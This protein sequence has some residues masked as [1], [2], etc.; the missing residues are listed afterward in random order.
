MK[1]SQI[2]FKSMSTFDN[3]KNKCKSFSEKFSSCEMFSMMEFIGCIFFSRYVCKT[4]GHYLILEFSPASR[5][6]FLNIHS[7]LCLLK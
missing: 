4:L 7:Q 6:S 2:T 1:F 5:N 3:Q